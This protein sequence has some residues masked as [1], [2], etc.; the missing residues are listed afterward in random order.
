M[1]DLGIVTLISVA[2]IAAAPPA[3][4]SHPTDFATTKS[5]QA[6]ADCYA[7]SQERQSKPWSFVPRESGGGTFSNLGARSVAHPYFLVIS[8]RGSRRVIQL[9]KTS[10]DGPEARGVEQCI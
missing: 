2:A 5:T 10:W 3:Q 6:F 7:R 9:Q 8:D 1:K 4:P